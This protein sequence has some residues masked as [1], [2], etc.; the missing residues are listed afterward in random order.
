MKFFLDNWV[1]ILIALSSGTMLALPALRGAGQ[2]ALTVQGAV[3]LI[4]REKAVLVDV[5]EAEEFAAG[6]ALGARNVP[7]GELEARLPAAVKNKTVPLLLLCASG[8]RARRALE[9]ARKLGYD[10][11][12][13]VAGGLRAWTEANLPTEKA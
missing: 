12:Q 1:L 11:A 9:T 13:V 2:G 6:H 10:K 3:Q 4:N 7:L 5:R 8:A